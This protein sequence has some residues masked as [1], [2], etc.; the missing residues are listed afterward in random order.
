MINSEPTATEYSASGGHRKCDGVAVRVLYHPDVA[1][2]SLYCL[3]GHS[4]HCGQPSNSRD[5]DS[6]I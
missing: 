2:S 1:S 5:V 6:E 3:P 4:G